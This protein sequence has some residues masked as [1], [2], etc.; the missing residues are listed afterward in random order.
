MI[1]QHALSKVL[2]TALMLAVGGLAA[3]ASAAGSTRAV[4][5]FND[6]TFYEHVDGA[7]QVCFLSAAPR[8][9]VPKDP[10]RGLVQVF[11]SAWPKDGV[12][13]EIS[14]KL[15]YPGK[16]GFPVTVT[17]GK[18]AF[19]LFATG[20][21]AFVQDATAELKLLEAVK[22][23]TQLVVQATP[24]VGAATTDTFSLQGLTQG[25]QSLATGCTG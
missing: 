22:K 9:S 12:K 1:G 23:G 16:K 13:G 24:E 25:L 3:P 20:D 15:G 4:S 5:K 14:V 19:R 7:T 21:R 11:V 6:W 17:V 2:S 18:D 8:T 10:Q